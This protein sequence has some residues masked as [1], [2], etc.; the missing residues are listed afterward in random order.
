M[1]VGVLLSLQDPNFKAFSVSERGLLDHMIVLVLIFWGTATLFSITATLF[2]IPTNSMKG[3]R[4]LQILINVQASEEHTLTRS[5]VYSCAVCNPVD[6][7]LLGYSVH[8]ITQ[9][10]I[11]EWFA[12]SFFRGPSW[13]SDWT[14][15]FP[16]SPALAAGFFITETP[17][18][19]HSC[20]NRSSFFFLIIAFLTSVR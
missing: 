3:I 8:G 10:R 16:V 2:C 5:W 6:C 18:K 12:I 14:H 7:G 1:D 15:I 13:P 20:K 9:A 17:G 4:F 19:S 11:L